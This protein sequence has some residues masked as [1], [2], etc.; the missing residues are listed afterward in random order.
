MKQSSAVV[1]AVQSVIPGH[2]VYTWDMVKP[3]INEIQ[4]ILMQGFLSGQ[5]ELSSESK[6]NESYL[7]KYIPGLVNNHVRKDKRLNGGT[8]YVAK[9]PGSRQGAG[10]AQL[11]ALRQLLTMVPDADK[12][13]IEAAIK[14]RQAE[15]APKTEID[16][17][18]LPEFLRN[19]YSQQ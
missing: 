14:A 9:N 12:P 17:S 16:L 15:L 6:R 11:K 3:H 13:E 10:D 7:T 18:A 4:A 1:A 8:E 19:K 5:I 2:E